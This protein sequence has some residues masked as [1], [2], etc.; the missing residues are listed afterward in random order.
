[1]CSGFKDDGFERGIS[2]GIIDNFDYDNTF[3]G[4]YEAGDLQYNGHHSFGN[5]ELIYWKETKNF[6][7]GCSAHISGG[8]YSDG[9]MALPDQAT[10]IIE[11]TSIGDGVSLE[12]NHHCNVGV[13]GVLCSPQYILHN[14]EWTNSDKSRKWVR[15]QHGGVFS[16]SPPNA[17]VIMNGGLIE[18]SFFPPGYVV[19]LRTD[20][21]FVEIEC[22][23]YH[24]LTLL[25]P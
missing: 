17:E 20:G 14:T 22:C 13:T 3:V 23:C 15:L 5:N 2:A 19:S 21:S 18:S 9:N 16:L 8:T 11:N 24:S 7:N 10:F 25:Y 1:M 4:H 12:A 6:A